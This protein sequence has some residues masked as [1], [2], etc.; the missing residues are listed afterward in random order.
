MFR[1]KPKAQFITIKWEHESRGNSVS[2]HVKKKKTKGIHFVFT[3][4]FFFNS[5]IFI[6]FEMASKQSREN[7]VVWVQSHIILRT[8][9]EIW[10]RDHHRRPFQ[11]TSSQQRC[12]LPKT[13]V[14]LVLLFCIL[15]S[16]S[17]TSTRVIAVSGSL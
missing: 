16:P 8:F 5:R 11:R 9:L 15:Y 7:Y 3:R 17:Y 12:W 13:D 2:Q 6:L 4:C 1:R 14:T 10:E